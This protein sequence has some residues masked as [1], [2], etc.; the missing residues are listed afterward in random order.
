MSDPTPRRRMAGRAL[1]GA[2]LL[3]LPLTASISYAAS[4][5]AASAEAPEAAEPPAPPAPPSPP[6]GPEAPL[7]PLPPGAPGMILIDT[8]TGKVTTDGDGDSE[9]TEQVWRDA[10]GKENRVRM[11]F[12][13]GPGGPAGPDP[14]VTER[15]I[16][17][18]RSENKAERE[19]AI[20]EMRAEA[21]AQRARR[22]AWRAMAGRM[23][24]DAARPP[25]PP[26]PPMPPRLMVVSGCTPGER[27]M[28][29]TK[30]GKDGKQIITIC[31]SR[32]DATAREGLESARDEIAKD[33][34]IPEETRKRVLQ[35][36]DAQ[37]ARWRGKVD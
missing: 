22:E 5:N 9:V 25:M 35:T 12:R 14:E 20:A 36:L 31:Q 16:E 17:A 7:P 1:L 33:N 13:G 34:S 18:L 30:D 19:A 27:D 21:E 32:I 24:G 3:V 29:E 4:E 6:G 23:D 10:D 11:V 28:V 37:I 26:M 8:R 2:G 15:R